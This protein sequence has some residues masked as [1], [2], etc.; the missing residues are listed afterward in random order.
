MFTTLRQYF[1]KPVFSSIEKWGMLAGLI[2]L[3]LALFAD[4]AVLKIVGALRV[5]PL[6]AFM[7]FMTDFGMLYC[8]I[9][10]IFY[11]LKNKKFQDFF[12]VG[13]TGGTALEISYLAKVLFQTPR[14]YAAAVVATIPLTQASG[15]SMPSL[16]TAF[17]FSLWPFLPRIFPTKKLQILSKAIILTI[18]LSRLYLG[19]HYLSDLIL[20]GMVG[21]A[22]ARFWIY[23][24]EHHKILEWFIYHVKDKLELR[25]QVAHV[26]TGATIVLLLKLQL[27]N[28]QVLFVILLL[29]GLLSILVRFYRIPVID[30]MLLFFE[31]PEDLKSFPGKGS[32]FLVLGALLSLQFFQQDIALAAISIMAVGDAITTIIGTYFGKIKNPLNPRK[33]LEGTALAIVASTLAAFFF[34]SFPVA[35]FGSVAGM[36]FESVTVRYIS[37]VVD[38]NVIIPVVAGLV[39]TLLS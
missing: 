39:M 27:L 13:L 3:Y 4:D 14:P 23:L 12:L 25:R 11:L 7:L 36:V 22:V 17:C 10:L 2:A 9:V 28:E 30:K 35:F 5:Y 34:V 18:A 29:G 19:V 8:F 20:G 38:D 16:H 32:F 31:R 33:H 6:D 15:F 37:Q 26:L 21:Y 1:V 24:E